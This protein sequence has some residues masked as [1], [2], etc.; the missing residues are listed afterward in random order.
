MIRKL[1]YISGVA[2]I[3]VVLNHAL[4][5]GFT[6]MFWWSHRYRP[7]SSPNFD[8][9]FSPSYFTL[10]TL[11]Q[12]VI[13]AVPAFLFIS[14]Y[15]AT[16]ALNR[17]NKDLDWKFAVN[18]IRVLIIPY[19]IWSVIFL[20]IEA[21]Q[22]RSFDFAEVMRIILLGGAAPG[23][24]FIP[25][26][27][28][29]YLLSPWIVK[30]GRVNWKL[31]LIITASIAL[32]LCVIRSWLI[33]DGGLPAASV[34]TALVAGWLFP[35]NLFWFA[36]GVVA[37]FNQ[38]LVRDTAERWRRGWHIALVVALI[39]GIIEGEV[40]LR[41]SGQEWL[42]PTLTVVD[43]FYSFV[44]LMVLIGM[45]EQYFIMQKR[46]STLGGRTYGIYLSH[47]LVLIVAAKGMYHLVP[48]L[49][50]F[51]LIFVA[52]LTF[53]GLLVPLGLMETIKRLPIRQSYKYLFG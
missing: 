20:A 36:F 37:G 48:G 42:A 17:K 25:L 50:R 12:L 29:L 38:K 40:L 39:A 23:F 27:C 1:P 13:F 10:R 19:L 21:A 18:R 43:I 16:L 5:W 2:T 51:S 45:R 44:V 26:L 3:C 46:I 53:V 35:A 34:L 33:L 8:E 30:W 47:G 15:Y 41:A 31:L 7:V 9:M 22:G 32:T 52:L 49:L 11:E 24:Y 28:Q 14:G 4:G 6:G